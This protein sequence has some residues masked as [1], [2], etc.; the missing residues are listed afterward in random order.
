M[1]ATP[2][3]FRRVGH[4]AGSDHIQIDINNASPQVVTGLNRCG[5][6]PVFPFS[7]KFE[8]KFP[9]MAPVAQMPDL[10]LDEMSIGA[11][12]DAIFLE[13]GFCP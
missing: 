13:Y 1:K 9:F 3:P 12:H 5:M 2:F 8:Q 4:D 6:I 11:R 10:S 7:G